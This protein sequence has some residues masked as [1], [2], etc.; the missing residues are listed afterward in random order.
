MSKKMNANRFLWANGFT[1]DKAAASN[2]EAYTK[3]C[4]YCGQN[5]WMNP[6][7][8]GRWECLGED[9]IRHRCYPQGKRSDRK[10]ANRKWK[11]GI[12]KKSESPLSSSTYS[13]DVP[14]WDESLGEAQFTDEDDRQIYQ[15]WLRANGYY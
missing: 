9:G 7:R 3:P 13:G 8:D 5:V 12:G 15:D 10:S 4:K 6:T 14:P 1:N 2:R 11:K